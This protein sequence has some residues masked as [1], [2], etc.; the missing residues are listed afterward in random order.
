MGDTGS[1]TPTPQVFSGRR[2]ERRRMHCECAKN[3]GFFPFLNHPIRK[4]FKRLPT[5]TEW[6]HFQQYARRMRKLREEDAPSPSSPEVASVMQ[7]CTISEPLLPNLKD[8][9][10]QGIGGWFIPFIPLFLSPRTTSIVLS[11]GSGLP[12]AMVASIVASLPTLCPGLETITLYTLS[13]NPMVTAAVSRMLLATHRNALQQLRVDCPLTEEASEMLYKLPNL[14]SLSV[15]IERGASLPSAS[16]P[17]L[18]HLEIVCDNED[19]WPQ[20]FHRATFGKLESVAFY[21]QSEQ[22]GDFLGTFER[23]ALSSS[24]QNTLSTF[25]LDTSYSWNPNYSSLLPFTQMVDLVIES[26]C[27]GG[28]SS[29]VDDDII[30]SLS[31]AMPKLKYLYLG[32][33]PCRQIAPG[34]TVKGLVAL[35]RHCPNLSTLRVHFQV[36]SLSDPPAIPEMVPNPGP[37]ASWI[38]CALEVLYVWEKPMPE[39]SELVIALTLLRIFPRLDSIVYFD[40]GWEEVEDAIKRSKRIIDCSSD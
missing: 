16:L 19:G 1:T 32:D 8:L 18:T 26:S 6:A 35:A 24:V 2:L 39:G 30:I 31:R 37:A 17:N 28:C 29:V 22:L 25:C 3:M 20:L 7:L 23:A 14:R 12:G 10:L 4:S 11:F 5:T 15:V 27:D 36:T 13:R 38:D 33:S 21:P 9:C 40:E 34:V